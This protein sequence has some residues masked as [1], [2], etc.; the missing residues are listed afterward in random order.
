MPAAVARRA[1]MHSGSVCQLSVEAAE[2]LMFSTRM[3]YSRAWKITHWMPSSTSLT[4]PVP[5]S[6]STRTSNSCAPGATPVE[7]GNW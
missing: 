6:P 7:S 5:S 4:L 3:L 2:R 1:A